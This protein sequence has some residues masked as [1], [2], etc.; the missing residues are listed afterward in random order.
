MIRARVQTSGW[1]ASPTPPPS[2]H[3]VPDSCWR[4]KALG[5]GKREKGTLRA[6]DKRQRI[7]VTGPSKQSKE[8]RVLVTWKYVVR[9]IAGKW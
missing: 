8:G 9:W 4:C 5:D 7:S 1:L 3:L 2:C 6:A